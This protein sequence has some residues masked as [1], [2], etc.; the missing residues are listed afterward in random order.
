[1]SD[2]SDVL[3][4]ERIFERWF[5]PLYPPDARE[6]LAAARATDANPANNP[7]IVRSLDEIAGTFTK[8]APSAFGRDLELDRSDA[9]VHRLGAALSRELRD[10][11][12][13]E[14]G[15]DGVPLLVHVVVHGAAYVGACV[16]AQHGGV[17]RVRRPLWES[18]VHLASRAGEADLA[19]FHWWLKSLSDAEIDR[20]TLADRYR[21]HVEVPC[22][23]AEDLPPIAPPDRRLPRLARVRYD[24]LHKHLRAHLPELRDVGEH[25]PTADRLAE[26]G[27][28]HLDFTWLGEGRMLLVHGPTAHGV[29]LFWLDAAGFVKGAFYPHDAAASYRLDVEGEKLVLE[30]VVHGKAVRHETLWWGP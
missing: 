3:T 29:H 5:W 6:D 21:T 23:R 18:L 30:T 15:P 1:M 24:T 17:W 28:R 19:I 22:L 25:F 14:K 9:S 8:L 16:V 13:N 2:E 11:W 20:A 26:L 12:A 4:A 10:R 27:F 7:S